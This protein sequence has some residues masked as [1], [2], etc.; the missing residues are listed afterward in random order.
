M[1]ISLGCQMLTMNTS[2]APT[3]GFSPSLREP[4]PDSMQRRRLK[5]FSHQLSFRAKSDQPVK[6]QDKPVLKVISNPQSSSRLGQIS[7]TSQSDRPSSSSLKNRNS[8]E[9]LHNSVKH[10]QEYTVSRKSESSAPSRT[11]GNAHTQSIGKVGPKHGGAA[12]FF[13]F[14]RKRQPDHLFPL[15]VKVNTSQH[16]QQDYSAQTDASTPVSASTHESVTFQDP[17]PGPGPKISTQRPPSIDVQGTPSFTY[18]TPPPPVLEDSALAGSSGGRN[19]SGGSTQS[20]TSTPMAHHALRPSMRSRSS[21][22]NSHPKRLEPDRVPT[23][24][25]QESGRSSTASTT[26][27]RNSIAGLRSLTSKL[28]HPSESHSPRFGSPGSGVAGT[29]ANNSFALS[30]ETLVVPEREEGET[31]GKYYTR[32]EGGIPKKSIALV[33]SKSPDNFSHDVLRS[34]MRT[35]KFYEEPM[36]MSMRKI[37]WEIDLPGEA[38]Q[39]DRVISAFAERYHE[40]NPHIFNTLGKI[41]FEIIG[42]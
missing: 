40:C 31:A 1:T 13:K 12:A 15:P 7:N 19:G 16:M 17:F 11:S 22:V 25:V 36:D 42:I 27:G 18:D 37:L 3:I 24:H 20:T 33:L 8:G 5:P 26:L 23:P 4:E 35:F 41:L 30:R 34:L 21:T 32:L 6:P 2:I 10:W 9:A 28:R 14:S 38:Q 29:S 39:I